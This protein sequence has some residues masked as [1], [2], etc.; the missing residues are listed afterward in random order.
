[1]VLDVSNLVGYN[2]DIQTKEV[3]NMNEVK[4]FPLRFSKDFHISIVEA[5]KKSDKSL[6]QWLIEAANEKMQKEKGEE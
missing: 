6:H 4:I 1:L 2:N 5:A 3:K